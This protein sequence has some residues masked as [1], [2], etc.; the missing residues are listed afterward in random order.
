MVGLELSVAGA[1]FVPR[2]QEGGLLINCTA[3]N[4]L[5]FLPPFVIEREHVDE[6]VDILDRAFSQGPPA[7]AS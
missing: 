1:E 7:S 6:A 5:R 2:T 3:G 4:V